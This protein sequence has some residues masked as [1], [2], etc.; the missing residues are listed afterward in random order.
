MKK[1]LC[2][3]TLFFFAATICFS[4]T[5]SVTEVSATNPTYSKSLPVL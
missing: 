5:G 2:L 1:T 3:F 4:S